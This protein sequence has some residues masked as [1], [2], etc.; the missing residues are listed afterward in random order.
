MLYKIAC[1]SPS[2]QKLIKR[3]VK[4]ICQKTPFPVLINKLA[5]ATRLYKPTKPCPTNIVAAVYVHAQKLQACLCTKPSEY[6]L[7]ATIASL[8][9][10]GL[11]AQGVVIYPKLPWFV[12]NMPPLTLY[13]QVEHI[14]CRNMSACTRAIKKATFQQN[15]IVAS[16]VF[17]LNN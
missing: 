13:A 15:G 1:S 7:V 8:L 16:L 9:T 2:P 10:F 11:D 3:T 12:E 17:Q 4:L 6:I 14:Q 5:D